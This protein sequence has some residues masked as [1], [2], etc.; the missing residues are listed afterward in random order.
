MANEQRNL[1]F[2]QTLDDS[3]NAQD[4]DIFDKRHKHDVVVRW[5]AQPPTHG[6]LSLP[7]MAGRT[8]G[9]KA[10]ASSRHSRITG[11]TTD[12]I[13]CCSRAAIGP[14]PSLVLQGL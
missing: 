7:P 8:T 10:S 14:A 3:W 5:P 1:E 4:W 13:R 2:M 11:F 12:R 9:P 6:R